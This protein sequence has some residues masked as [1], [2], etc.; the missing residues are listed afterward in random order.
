MPEADA[1]DRWIARETTSFS[2]DKPGTFHPAV[3]RL[4]A[5]HGDALELLGLGEPTHG[6]EDILRLRNALFQHLV[7]AHGFTA[8]AVESSFPRGH[9]VNEYVLGRGPNTYGEVQEK[10]FSHGF[11][12]LA[13]N[14]DLVEWMRAY[15]ADPA[16]PVKLRFYG[17]DSPTEMTGTDSP[18]QSLEFALAY[19]AALDSATAE[20]HRTVIAPLLDADWE[21]PAAVMDHTKAIGLSP[22]ASALRVATEELAGE[23]QRRCPE[24]VAGSTPERYREAAQHVLGAR[25]LL[26]YHAE[27][28][29][30]SGDRV[31]RLLGIRDATM[32]DHLAYA[33]AQER[34]RGRVF[35]FAHNSHLQ[36]SRAEWQ[37]G[38]VLNA[39]WPA[40][41]HLHE[42]LGERYAVIGTAIAE[43]P[44]LGLTQ[45]EPGTL[46][47]RMLTAPG[48]NRW[49]PTPRG[50]SLSTQEIAALP[51]RTGSVRNPGYF[52]WRPQSITDFDWLALLDSSIA[53]R[54]I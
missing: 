30:P 32:A 10:G 38:P 16:H 26:N 52:P 2:P 31:A 23:L 29:R 19:L 54:A 18:R 12:R 25:Q 11:G 51:V 5:A 3:A 41:A 20:A 8:I 13:A 39:W 34:G 27:L 22:G 49:M 37:W 35:A 17:F 50:Q 21:N 1:L 47:A 15:N 24:F 28:A 6:S 7:E 4:V 48:P 43:S 53:Q 45:P 36:R 46:E 14:R 42:M 44:A 33:V 40:G 9:W